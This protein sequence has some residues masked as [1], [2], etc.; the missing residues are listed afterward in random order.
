MKQSAGI[1]LYRTVEAQLEVFLTHPGGPIYGHKDVWSIPKGEVDEGETLQQAAIREFYEETGATV[2]LDD[3]L[4]LGAFA[5]NTS[6]M[7]YIF[8]IERDFNVDEFVCASTFSMQWP[9]KSGVVQTYA[10]NDKAEWFSITTAAHKL[11][12]PQVIFLERLA[13]QLGIDFVLPE[14]PEVPRQQSLL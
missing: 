1:L 7:N 3:C 2:A 5:Q 13:A 6:K 10:E 8:A 4:D 9:P 11:F 12:P 14:S